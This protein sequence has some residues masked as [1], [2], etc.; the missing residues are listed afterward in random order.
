[1]Q[2]IHCKR[3]A[4]SLTVHLAPM[5]V[6]AEHLYREGRFDLGEQF[7]AEANVPDADRIKAPY[8]SL[9]AVL[10]EVWR[11]TTA[12]SYQSTH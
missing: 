11:G 10:E 1:M 4:A 9:H 6:I 12:V 2:S 8:L 7:V 5:Q 3:I